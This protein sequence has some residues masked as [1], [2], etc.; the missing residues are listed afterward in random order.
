MNTSNTKVVALDALCALLRSGH[1]IRAAL[2]RWVNDGPAAIGTELG[3][4]A[5]RIRLGD[6]T[7]GSL[8]PLRDAF[9][10]DHGSLVTLVELASDMGGD[11]SLMLERLARVIER[12]DHFSAAGRSAGAGAVLSAR[13]VAGL[14]L[15]FLP[16]TP[17]ARAPLFDAI[18]IVILIVG[19]SL[20]GAG[21]LWIDRVVP[22]PS[23][24]DD[25]AAGAA[26]VIAALVD[27]GVSVSSCLERI[28]ATDASE[29]TTELRA[30]ARR[31]ALGA[32]WARA[33]A[34]S[35]DDGLRD[36]GTTMERAGHMGLPIGDALVA[37]AERR[38]ARIHHEFEA[39]TK[40]APVA[41]V[42]PLVLC[43]L[44]SFGLLALAPFLRG[45]VAS[46]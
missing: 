39:A 29:A 14:P 41:M 31:V 5:A 24:A 38:R 19:I 3:R 46:V 6:S 1:S 36:L 10:S 35:S 16:L 22:R 25:L 15:A 21:M 43:V 17:V 32:T 28:A 18:G 45:L 30:A 34:L 42:V 8:S 9:G 2:E 20:A 13:M 44:P 23:I 4:V 11:A 12:R 37:L 7:V 33:L 40:R 27:G 26:E